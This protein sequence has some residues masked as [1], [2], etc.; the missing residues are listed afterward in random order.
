MNILY[1]NN[2][3]RRGENKIDVLWIWID[4]KLYSFEMLII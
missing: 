3:K 4:F 1:V 2:C